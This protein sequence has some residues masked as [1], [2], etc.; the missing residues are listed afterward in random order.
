MVNL[1]ESKSLEFQEC[2]RVGRVGLKDRAPMSFAQTFLG[3]SNLIKRHTERL[4]KK[5]KISEFVS[6]VM[7][8]LGQVSEFN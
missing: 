6:A 1:L 3:W 8:K 2:Y 5:L 4:K 7:V